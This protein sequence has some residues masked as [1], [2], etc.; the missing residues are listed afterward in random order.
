VNLEST[1]IPIEPRLV[2]CNC[3]E[4]AAEI[5][6]QRLVEERLAACVNV[7]RNVTSIYRWEGKLCMD[8]EHSL[9]IKTMSDRLPALTN[10]IRE[11]HPYS[12]PEV[13]SLALQSDEGEPRYLAW[14][15][16]ETRPGA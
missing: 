2:L 3:P 9:L 13:I 6:A 16:A 15:A 5:I 8:S 4:S 14:L 10:R 11:L 7:I 12:L 1:K